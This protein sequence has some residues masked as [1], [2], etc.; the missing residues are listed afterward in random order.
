MSYLILA[1]K[2]RPQTFEEVV[3]Q[4]HITTT[5]QNAIK[6]ERVAQSFLFSGGRGIGKTS[7]ARIFAKALNCEKGPA[8]EPCGKCISCDEIS[9]GASLDVLEIDGASNRGI[10][11][12]RDLRENVKFKP[13]HGRFKVYIIDEVHMLTGEAFNALLKTLEEPPPHVKFIFATTEPHK[14]PL[15]ILSRCQRF[16][17]R[18]IP[19]KEIVAKL[20]E[21]AEKEK[22]KVSEKVLFLIARTAESSLR[23][24]ESL[25]EQIASFS[26]GKV[27]EE[28]ALFV[29]GATD[30]KVYY[31]L[32]ETV[33]ARDVAGSL[34]SVHKAAEEGKDL[35]Q[36]TKGLMEYFRN[37]LVAQVVSEP[38][39]L[40]DL[41][42]A[43]IKE[44]MI[45][46]ERFTKEEI[47]YAMTVLQNVYSQMRKSAMPRI[48]LETAVV[49]LATRE[50]M[51]SL[52]Q[53]LDELN[54]LEQDAA[55]T[56]AHSDAAPAVY[57][58]R[59]PEPKAEK[60][61]AK[62]H[63]K[64]AVAKEAMKEKPE[65]EKADD[66]PQPS[67]EASAVTLIE[68][69]RHWS[70]VIENLKKRKMYVAVAL[71]EAE[72]LEVENS[73]IIVGI[74]S[75]FKFHKEEL[76]ESKPSMRLIEEVL[77][78][79]FQVPLKMKFVVTETE[80]EEKSAEPKPLEEKAVPG[81]VDSAVE[82]FGGR[83]VRRK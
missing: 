57:S 3:G 51:T 31:D 79:V 32:I 83:V 74:P 10:D 36:F 1:R 53:I 4:E 45:Q 58:G 63:V 55:K 35:S 64:E 82:I 23:D 49:K 47:I 18:R 73:S 11:E 26:P 68:V 13:A 27:D 43:S 48:Y 46:R 37:L 30:E 12:I 72:P 15:T 42:E 62:P 78:E 14:V 52:T 22:M 29:L 17:F 7:T 38:D 70:D 20:K 54:K 6:Q 34:Q 61:L 28:K 59:K 2:Y 44:L 24:A 65:K 9:R 19:V 21:V 50:P 71:A 40:M 67:S 25:L 41:D 76:L 60:P 80:R 66:P 69:E 5:L 77:K 8:P 39:A 16:H 33:A 56:S 75:E 81:I